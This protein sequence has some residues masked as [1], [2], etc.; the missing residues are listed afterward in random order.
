M[1]AIIELIINELGPVC[2]PRPLVRKADGLVR[3]QVVWELP[4]AGGSNDKAPTDCSQLPY[5]R[6]VQAGRAATNKAGGNNCEV[7]QLAVPGAAVPSGSGWYYDDFSAELKTSCHSNE[8]QRV[9]FSSDA[10]P[11]TGVLVKLECLNETQVVANTRSD[12]DL[13]SVQPGIGTPCG[14]DVSTNPVS[15]D[16]AC[17]VT[18]NNGQQDHGLFCHPDLN[19]CVQA[20]G[21]DTEC[22]P[23]WVC[24][25]RP[26]TL[27]SAAGRG[28][29][30]VNP[31]CGAD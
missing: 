11:P 25:T 26:T 20:C 10:K 17:V 2:L 14:S 5:L 3:C 27:A 13:R 16:A 8:Q 24:D 22:P 6:P 28:A 7:T 12:L 18:L 29:Y 23:A 9:A 4:K 15:G 1:D 30:C 19:V 31:T 21:S